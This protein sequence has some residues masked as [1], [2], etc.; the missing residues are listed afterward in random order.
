MGM[1]DATLFTLI[2]ILLGAALAVGT[3]VALVVVR[4]A[5]AFITTI[6]RGVRRW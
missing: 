6:Y 4:Y 5:S 1:S 2:V 3:L